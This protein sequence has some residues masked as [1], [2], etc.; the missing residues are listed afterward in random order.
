MATTEGSPR[1]ASLNGFKTADSLMMDAK[2]DQT[3]MEE[4]RDRVFQRFYPLC[5]SFEALRLVDNV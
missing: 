2:N 1:S 4:E 5:L 3:L